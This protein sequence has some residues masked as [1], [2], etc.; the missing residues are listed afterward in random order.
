MKHAEDILL[1]ADALGQ[2]VKEGL[3]EHVGRAVASF[4]IAIAAIFTFTEIAFV[5]ISAAEFT[6]EA[7]VLLI[8]GLVMYLSLES[9]GQSYAK[10][11]DACLRRG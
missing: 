8:S 7:T 3:L 11:Q 2:R 5:G 9:E 10:T 6:L 1:E 4:A